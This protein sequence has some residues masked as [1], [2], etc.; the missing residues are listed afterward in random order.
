MRKL[1]RMRR[2]LSF[3]IL[4][5][6][7]I[8]VITGCRKNVDQSAMMGAQKPVSMDEI[9]Q[10]TSSFTPKLKPENRPVFLYELAQK[11]IVSGRLYVRV[12]ALGAK[13]EDLGFFYFTKTPEG[14]LQ[15]LY[16]QTNQ[17]DKTKPDGMVGFVDFDNKTYTV[18]TYQNNK[19]VALYG[20][21]DTKDLFEKAFGGT[22]NGFKVNG[23]CDETTSIIQLPDGKDSIITKKVNS[24]TPCGNKGQTFW[25]WLGGLFVSIWQGE[26]GGGGISGIFNWLFGWFGNGS[27]YTGGDSFG[28]G[29]YNDWG[30]NWYVGLGYS[31]G[32][33]DPSIGGGPSANDPNNG[34][35]VS[36]D[37]A[38]QVN[39]DAYAQGLGYFWEDLSNDRN[40][41][42]SPP[43]NPSIDGSYDAQG[44]RK[45]GGVYNYSEGTIQNYTNDIGHYYSVF[46]RPDGTTVLFPGATI[47]NHPVWPGFAWTSAWGGIHAALSFTLAGLQHEYGHY[48]QA[49]I[50]GAYE[51]NRII[52]PQ[53]FYSGATNVTN[54]KYFW[55]E[56]EANRLSVAFFGQNSDIANKPTIYPQ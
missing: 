20:M 21:K 40:G 24:G 53:S 30:F 37:P 10:W 50:I 47:T 36:Y 23:E 1:S 14:T 44:Y 2:L 51:Y 34:S 13:A 39:A 12:P 45:M 38:Y 5:L 43:Y 33:I 49:Q 54:H 17:K 41:I 22:S 18:A 31:G 25:Q 46:T 29:G 27:S 35:W 28:N 3:L 42:I 16:I 55:T 56:R 4:A 6:L 26:N 48:L 9:K 32:Y 8:I 52:L 7:S 11:T 15:S 19:P